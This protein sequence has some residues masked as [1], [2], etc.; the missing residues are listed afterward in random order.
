MELNLN[1]FTSNSSACFH[2]FAIASRVK[3][4]TLPF[5]L[6]PAAIRSPCR[7]IELNFV[8]PRGA[9]I[10][11]TTCHPILGSKRSARIKFRSATS[12]SGRPSPS[13]SVVVVFCA[14]AACA[15]PNCAISLLSKILNVGGASFASPSF[16]VSCRSMV[17]GLSGVKS[18]RSVNESWSASSAR[19][20]SGARLSAPSGIVT[21]PVVEPSAGCNSME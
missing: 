12:N 8:S 10:C 7:V 20:V 19:I 17:I 11:S 14:F 18:R 1:P 4:I 3:I 16:G 21:L 9:L 2:F 15:K 6:S 5:S 13:I